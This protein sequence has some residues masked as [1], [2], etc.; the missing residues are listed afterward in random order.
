[1]TKLNIIYAVTCITGFILQFL[2]LLRYYDYS[3]ALA[4]LLTG[5][6]MFNLGTVVGKTIS[7]E[8]K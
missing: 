2:A 1:M 7:P 8:N 4:H 3:V 5:L 6:M